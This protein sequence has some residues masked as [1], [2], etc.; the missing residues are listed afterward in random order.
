MIVD[1]VCTVSSLTW[2]HY[3][4]LDMCIKQFLVTLSLFVAILG[5]VMHIW[6]YR[7]LVQFTFV[8]SEK[9]KT[10]AI[11]Q[12]C[13]FRTICK[14]LLTFVIA[15]CCV[16]YILLR[17]DWSAAVTSHDKMANMA[18]FLDSTCLRKINLDILISLVL[19]IKTYENEHNILLVETDTPRSLYILDKIVKGECK[20]TGPLP[21]TTKK[22]KMAF[23]HWLIMG[24]RRLRSIT[25]RPAGKKF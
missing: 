2:S 8:P 6:S 9:F 24:D 12:T 15:M 22:G 19:I 7:Y 21:K 13:D 11:V 23:P 18:T 16:V 25:G 10:F 14:T 5:D 1:T 20:E 3:F 17:S 4:N